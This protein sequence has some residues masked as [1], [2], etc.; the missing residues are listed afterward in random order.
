MLSSL[1]Y[2]CYCSVLYVEHEC[3][4]VSIL[5]YV[6]FAF[7]SY[8]A[9]L[10]CSRHTSAAKAVTGRTVGLCCFGVRGWM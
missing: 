5:Y 8:Q 2:N 7:V 3:D 6:F 9:F 10:L 1:S 4:Y